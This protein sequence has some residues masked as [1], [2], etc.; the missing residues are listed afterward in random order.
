[1]RHRQGWCTLYIVKGSTP[2]AHVRLHCVH[3]MRVWD[4]FARGFSWH[5]DM[6]NDW[7][8]YASRTTDSKQFIEAA[9]Q[10]SAVSRQDDG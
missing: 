10:S 9:K 2:E 4:F 3:N 1:M 8:I 6:L 7:S 5:V